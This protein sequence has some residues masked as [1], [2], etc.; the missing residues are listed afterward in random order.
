MLY[1]LLIVEDSPELLEIMSN[2]FCEEGSG[3][4]TVDI[5][6]NGNDAMTKVTGETYDL[7]ILDIMLPGASGIDICKASRSISDC[8]KL[9]Y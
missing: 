4:W 3:L 2:F 7:M 5:A 9:P 6:N 8:P 1:R